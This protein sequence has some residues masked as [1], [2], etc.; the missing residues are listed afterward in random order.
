MILKSCEHLIAPGSDYFVSVPSA[1]AKELF[2]YPLYIGH[3][4][5]ETGYTLSRDSYDSFLIMYIQKGQMSVTLSSET[6]VAREGNF[7][8]LDCYHPHAY[9]TETGCEALWCHFDGVLAGAWFR[10][11]TGQLGNVFQLADSYPALSKLTALYRQFAESAPVR[12]P[13]FSKYLSDILTAFL[14]YSPSAVRTPERDGSMEETI[15]YINEHFAEDLPVE[16]LAAIAALS[17]YHFIRSFRKETGF[18][19]HEYL[20]NIR[21]NTAKYLLKNSGLSIKDICFRTGFSSESVFCSAFKKKLGLTP[22][23]YRHE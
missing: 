11:I 20:V 5:Y 1:T 4:I 16:K 7:I 19:P 23:E 22:L 21:L 8:L 17:P 14:L 2:F 6:Y 9:A 3:F 15:T 18:T 13:L 12:E 10:M